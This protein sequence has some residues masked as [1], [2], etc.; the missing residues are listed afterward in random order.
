[1]LHEDAAR[2]CCLTVRPLGRFAFGKTP[3]GPRCARQAR[4]RLR[5][6]TKM[7]DAARR[8]RRAMR[9]CAHGH[10]I[11]TTCNRELPARFD[12]MLAISLNQ[13][14]RHAARAKG[15]GQSKGA[16]MALVRAERNL[17]WVLQETV[18][19]N[20]RVGLNLAINLRKCLIHDCI[21]RAA[22]LLSTFPCEATKPEVPRQDCIETPGLIHEQIFNIFVA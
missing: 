12:L 21:C 15:S 4:Q 7:Q 9:I 5:L 18:C 11:V 20:H 16:G 14:L 1:M 17:A 19:R 10:I 22:R 2:K 3:R 8:T 6:A 13:V